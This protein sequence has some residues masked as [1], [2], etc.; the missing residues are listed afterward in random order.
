MEEIRYN[1]AKDRVLY[2]NHR[3][4]NVI[5]LSRGKYVIVRM[6]I[7]REDRRIVRFKRIDKRSYWNYVEAVEECRKIEGKK[8]KFKGMKRRDYA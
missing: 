8:V 7:R 4:G 1:T 5:I 6:V 3:N 2:I